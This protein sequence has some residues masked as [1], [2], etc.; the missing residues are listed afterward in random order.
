MNTTIRNLFALF[1]GISIACIGSVAVEA[2]SPKVGFSFG[3]SITMKI[4]KFIGDCPGTQRFYESVNFN[5]SVYPP[6]SGRQ[7]KL[8]NVSPG[9]S[10]ERPWALR[11]YDQPQGSENTDIILGSSHEDRYFNLVSGENTINFDIIESGQIL[12]QGVFNVFVNVNE[13]QETRNRTWTSE[14]YCMTN[15]ST[16]M[17]GCE[18]PGVREKGTCPNGGN[19]VYRNAH[20]IYSNSN[21]NNN[22]SDL[23]N[24]IKAIFQ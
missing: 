5:S 21:N 13:T 3:N 6:M 16:Y 1:S 23:N 20:S 17:D 19:P 8:E 12:E 22:E 14:T 4:T 7:V 2:Q 10:G 15:N 18:Y 9:T 24:L 11:G